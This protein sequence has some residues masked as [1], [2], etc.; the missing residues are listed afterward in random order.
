MPLPGRAAAP[1]THRRQRDSRLPPDL[2][3]QIRHVRRRRL[4]GLRA[5][6]FRG[7]AGCG[8]LPDTLRAEDGSAETRRVAA[9]FVPPLVGSTLCASGIGRACAWHLLS[10]Q[11]ARPNHTNRGRR[12]STGCARSTD[13]T[14]RVR[15]SE[16]KAAAR[17]VP[18]VIARLLCRARS[19]VRSYRAPATTF[20]ECALTCACIWP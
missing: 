13:E 4:R 17:P 7:P 8:N 15:P 10:A 1:A 2:C 14:A 16:H 5:L 12:S 19:I 9:R 11:R 3:G 20:P 18:A 6:L